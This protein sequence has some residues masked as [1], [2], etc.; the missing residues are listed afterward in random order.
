MSS[1]PIPSLF[2]NSSFLK[3]KDTIEAQNWATTLFQD[4]KTDSRFECVEWQVILM[5]YLSLYYD[6]H[7]YS[8]LGISPHK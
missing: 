4:R 5:R 6:S 8:C 3:E 7:S 2:H 1:Y